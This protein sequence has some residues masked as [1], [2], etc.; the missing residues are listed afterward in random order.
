MRALLKE[1]TLRAVLPGQNFANGQNGVKIWPEMAK[2][3][4][5]KWPAK[6]PAFCP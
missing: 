6:W 2:F 1:D 3:R 5:Y 4:F